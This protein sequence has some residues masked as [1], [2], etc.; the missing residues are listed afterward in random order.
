MNEF[1]VPHASLSLNLHDTDSKTN[2]AWSQLFR[3]PYTI[4]TESKSKPA[5]HKFLDVPMP[6]LARF[7]MLSVDAGVTSMSLNIDGAKEQLPLPHPQ[8]TQQCVTIECQNASWT[9]NYSNGY[10]VTLKGPLSA[11]ISVQFPPMPTPT[12][13]SSSFPYHHHPLTKIE[14]LKFDARKVVKAINVNA[15]V[16]Q[17]AKDPVRR[18]M[19]VFKTEGSSRPGSSAGGGAG[20]GLRALGSSSNESTPRSDENEERERTAGGELV[21]EIADASIPTEPV[22]AFGVPGACMRC[23]EVCDLVLALDFFCSFLV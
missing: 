7:F 16:G 4:P 9:Y 22:N 10:I 8:A 5:D 18:R 15:I 17:R 1:F 14:H 6:V 11:I 21:I 2:G 19:P 23:L 3:H 20:M 12:S 13:P